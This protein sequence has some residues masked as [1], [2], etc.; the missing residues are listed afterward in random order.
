MTE[1]KTF[2]NAN[3]YQHE[4]VNKM[5]TNAKVVITNLFEKFFKNPSLLPEEHQNKA[6]ARK[7]IGGDIAFAR[8]I[9]DYIAGM[10]DRY[11]QIEYSR[12][13]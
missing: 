11:A 13:N 8:V 7:K 6:L 2:L 3:L 4:Q 12:I 10:T 1:L 5:S 9:A